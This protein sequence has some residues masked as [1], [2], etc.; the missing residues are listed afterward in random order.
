MFY[1]NHHLAGQ[2]NTPPMQVDNPA[3]KAETDA[4]S[5]LRSHINNQ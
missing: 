1:L 2:L 4:G 5:F 3:A